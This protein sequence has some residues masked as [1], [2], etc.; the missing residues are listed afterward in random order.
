Y[1]LTKDREIILT[2]RN[3]SEIFLENADY[4]SEIN[5]VKHPYEKGISA[6]KGIE[7]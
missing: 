7:Y 2:G 3:P 6:R 5:S 1:I 4:I